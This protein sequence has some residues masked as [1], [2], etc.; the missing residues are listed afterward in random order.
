MTFIVFSLTNLQPNLE[1]LAKSEASVRM[2]DDQVV[3]WIANNGF[4]TP[5]ISRYGQW[6][7]VVPAHVAQGPDGPVGRCLP[8]GTD[9]ANAP[10]FCGTDLR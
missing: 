5:M 7:G 1:K 2:T 3:S 8:R 6:L 4:D 9:P 10:S